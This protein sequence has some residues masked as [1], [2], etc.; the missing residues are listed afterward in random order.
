MNTIFLILASFAVFAI[1]NIAVVC[2]WGFP[3]SLSA[4]FYS[5]EGLWRW[6]FTA[7]MF[8]TSFL[9]MPAWIELASGFGDWR[10]NL[11]FLSFLTCALICFVG[12]APHF[13]SCE[14]ES[15]VHTISATASAVTALAWCLVCGWQVMYIPIASAV[16]VLGVALMTKTLKAC[17]VY[18]LE[19]MAFVATFATVGFL[20]LTN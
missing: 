7:M 14:L 2:K 6:L 16:L 11:A 8:T 1:Y 3:T 13:R 5:F 9:L 17:K 10:D 15:K 18:W 12:A 19:M 4:T 20:T